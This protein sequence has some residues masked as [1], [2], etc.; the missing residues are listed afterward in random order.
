MR[1]PSP[2]RQ[3][4]FGLL[5][6]VIVT[7][8]IAFS[9]VVGYAGV[10]T[11]KQ[12]NELTPRHNKTLDESITLI[13]RMWAQRAFTL[14]EASGSNPTTI[15][16]VLGLAGVVSSG[17]MQE[18]LSN[19]LVLPAEGLAYRAVVLYYPSNTDDLNPPDLAGFAT[20]GLFNSCGN[21]GEP[22][23]DRVFRVFNS[24]EVER[25]LAKETTARLQKA[26]TK[27]QSYFKARMLQ[28]PERNISVNYFRRPMGACEVLVQDLGC[29]DTYTS[30]VSMNSATAYD[31]LRLAVNLGLTDEE[32]FT[33]WGQ[34]IEVSNLQDSSTTEAP[35]SMVFRARRPLGGFVSVIAIQQI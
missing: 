32:L 33:A 5:V 7:A 1:R 29:V 35:F 9:I 26:A 18:A 34:P 28:D 16:T 23:D 31:R 13:E 21:P 11:R 12:L 6:F 15:G 2:V 3:Q 25:A 19:V 14:D 10:M 17:G 27:A 8:I 4:G 22:C 20:T 30:M 24:V